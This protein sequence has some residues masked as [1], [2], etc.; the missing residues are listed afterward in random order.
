[1]G[2]AKTSEKWIQAGYELF[3]SE[4]I[5]GV[6]VER[7]A[8]MLGLNKSG[9][10]HYFVD[11][12]NFSRQLIQHHFTAFDNFIKDVDHCQNID[13]EYIGVLINHK[14]TIMAQIHLVR[15]RGNRLL[16]DVHKELD[17]K[18]DHAVLRIWADHIQMPDNLNLALE[19][20]RLIRDVFYSRVNPENF[21]YEYLH[22]LAEE[23]KGIVAKMIKEKTNV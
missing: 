19:Y 11:V 8:R 12:D 14:T 3:A 15:N 5:D 7:L 21:N 9:F 1:M 18:I 13:P 23:T 4:G 10:Y 22:T 16:S 2:G 17:N 6:H 20:H